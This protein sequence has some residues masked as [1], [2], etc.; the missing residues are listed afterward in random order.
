MA[1]QAALDAVGVAIA[2][3]PYVSD[4]LAAGRLFAPFPLIAH[5]VGS[6]LLEYRAIRKEYP[7][8]LAFRAWLHQEA[9]LARQVEI[10]LGRANTNGSARRSAG[11]PPRDCRRLRD[12]E[13]HGASDTR[14]I[15][16]SYARFTTTRHRL[17][18]RRPSA[19]PVPV[20]TPAA[21]VPTGTQTHP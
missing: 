10:V 7:A 2:H 5:T 8:L 6:C 16:P 20:H 9:D 11:H 18:P 13:L 19:A 15:C 17:A 14:R 21:P 1:M 3:I 12:V 4:S